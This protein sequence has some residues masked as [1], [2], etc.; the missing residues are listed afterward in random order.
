MN[1]IYSL[2]I[3]SMVAGFITSTI[4]F[5]LHRGSWYNKIKKNPI[6]FFNLFVSNIYQFNGKFLGAVSLSVSIAASIIIGNLLYIF[7][8][9]D[10]LVFVFSDTVKILFGIVAIRAAILLLGYSL[11]Y[12]QNLIQDQ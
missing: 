10:S 3:T 1:A 11:F 9:C 12:D 6:V 4:A 7:F 2:L 8:Y 5:F